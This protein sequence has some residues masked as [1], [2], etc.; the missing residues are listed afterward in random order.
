MCVLFVTRGPMRVCVICW[1]HTPYGK[2]L[3]IHTQMHAHRANRARKCYIAV[4][5]QLR[6]K[7][8]AGKKGRSG[9]TRDGRTS[10]PHFE[11]LDKHT[12]SVPSGLKHIHA[13]ERRDGRASAE[14]LY[15]PGKAAER[16]PRLNRDNQKHPKSCVLLVTVGRNC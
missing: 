10:E 8:T 11:R 12:L 14:S 16:K 1:P 9:R 4:N 13:K 3:H 15:D 7:R 6:C 2:Q 5:T